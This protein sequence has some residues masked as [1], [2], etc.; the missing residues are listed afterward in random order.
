[1]CGFISESIYLVFDE[2]SPQESAEKSFD[3][4]HMIRAQNPT[5]V[6]MQLQVGCRAVGGLHR[7]DQVRTFVVFAVEKS[8]EDVA[9]TC[10][11]MKIV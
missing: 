5:E 4:F 10:H 8:V 2:F 3:G 7:T 1:M 6:V 9:E 11:V